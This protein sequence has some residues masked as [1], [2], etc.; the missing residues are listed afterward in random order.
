MIAI[1]YPTILA[2]GGLD[3]IHSEVGIFLDFVDAAE[4]SAA[5][6]AGDVEISD[7]A[8]EGGGFILM[9][10]FSCSALLMLSSELKRMRVLW[11]GRMSLLGNGM[12][13][14]VPL[15]EPI[16]SCFLQNLCHFH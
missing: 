3:G 2:L 9:D 4:D 10:F 15:R 12:V 5:K 11:W 7:K 13:Y 16:L 14:G 8:A 1:G 6:V